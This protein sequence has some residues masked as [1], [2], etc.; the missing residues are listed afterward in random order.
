MS[1]KKVCKSSRSIS[2]LDV[3]PS[4]DLA[5]GCYME[6]GLCIGFDFGSA[7]KK[8]GWGELVDVVMMGVSKVC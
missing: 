8:E 7:G 5:V 1:Q 3:A 2:E 6:D 4:K